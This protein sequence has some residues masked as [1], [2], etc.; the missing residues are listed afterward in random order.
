MPKTLK[1]TNGQPIN[2]IYGWTTAIIALWEAEE[3]RAVFVGWDTL[4]VPTYRHKLWPPYQGG[5]HFDPE[6]VAQLNVLPELCRAFDFGVGKAAGYEADDV[7]AAAVAAEVAEGGSCLVLTNDRDSYQLVSDRVTVLTKVA[8]VPELV[9]IDPLAVEA[10]FGVR[11]EQVADFKALAGDSSDG[12][13]GA[14]GV[15]PK[16]AAALLTKHGDL[17]AVLEA[18]EGPLRA[19]AERLLLFRELV[20]MQADVAVELPADG[21]P[22]WGK[23]AAYLREIGAERLAPKVEE[24]GRRLL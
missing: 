2:A 9:R 20:R 1:G 4:G 23:A 24:K 7:I 21:P 13:P 15:G 6:I 22:N 12:I 10:H 18:T 5:R 11:P 8:R 16:S 14:R 19:D 17:Q 3:P